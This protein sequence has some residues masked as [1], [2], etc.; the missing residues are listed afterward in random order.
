M[1]S[2]SITVTRN[3]HD[4]HYE[5]EYLE[6]AQ[7]W[8]AGLQQGLVLAHHE[9]ASAAAAAPA[10]KPKRTHAAAPTNGAAKAAA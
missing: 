9:P 5:T 1:P 4:V 2:I 6:N 8:L 3:G 7:L 10:P